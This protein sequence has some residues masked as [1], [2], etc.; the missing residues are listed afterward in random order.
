MKYVYNTIKEIY[1]VVS[2]RRSQARYSNLSYPYQTTL[3]LEG[4]TVISHSHS[5]FTLVGML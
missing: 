1:E 5:P 2:F 4:T 3:K